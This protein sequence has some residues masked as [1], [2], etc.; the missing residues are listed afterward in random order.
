MPALLA[1]REG[2]AVVK[3]TGLERFNVIALLLVVEADGKGR[4]SL[5]Q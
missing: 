4:Q 1:Q 5:Q 2:Q 3:F